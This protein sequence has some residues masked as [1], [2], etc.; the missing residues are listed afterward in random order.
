M[1]ANLRP[2]VPTDAPACA[3]IIKDWIAGTAWHPDLFSL[4]D[5]AENYRTFALVERDGYV[6]ADDQ[7]CGF[8]L[9]DTDACVTALYVDGRR[10]GAGLGKTLLDHAKAIH[11]DGLNLW[12]AVPNVD[13]I[14]FYRREGFVETGACEVDDEMNFTEVELAWAPKAAA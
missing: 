7:V 12:P 10:R 5:I 2:A 1:Q 3:R 6:L 13:A 14:R 4:D 11:P 8:V 9:I